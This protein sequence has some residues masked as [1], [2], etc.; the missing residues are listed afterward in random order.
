M[1]LARSH[2]LVADSVRA[3]V[4]DY[5]LNELSLIDASEA[6]QGIAL[7]QN[8]DA[9]SIGSATF[10][11]DAGAMLATEHRLG[12][13]S[14]RVLP[15]AGNRHRTLIDHYELAFLMRAPRLADAG[16][17]RLVR[18]TGLAADGVTS[19]AEIYRE[20]VR[21]NFSRTP[22]LLGGAVGSNRGGGSAA[23][24]TFWE[25]ELDMIDSEGASRAARERVAAA[26]TIQ[27]TPLVDAFAVMI[28]SQL[29]RVPSVDRLVRS[30]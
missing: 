8:L 29:E 19:V 12:R 11:A 23:I 20:E 6:F 2:G 30:A 28:S 27:L 4:R 7:G 17:L 10:W 15:G 9:G 18:F 26:T 1:R 3:V 14:E 13:V 22:G 5:R 24:V 16:H 21:G 25:S